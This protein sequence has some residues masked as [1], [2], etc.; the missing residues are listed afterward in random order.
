MKTKVE[1]VID[2][3]IRSRIRAFYGKSG[4][5]TR[6]EIRRFVLDE[7]EQSVR[8]L[9]DAKPKRLAPKC[10]IC[11]R[12]KRQAGK[13]DELGRCGDC[14]KAAAAAPDASVICC[15]CGKPHGEHGGRLGN[16]CPLSRKVKP[17]S[18]FSA[19]STVNLKLEGRWIGAAYPETPV[20]D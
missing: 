8:E 14:L 11:Q 5:A 16:A 6:K 4:K 7:L 12:P 18:T 20:R 2:D 9:P 3:S 13:L 15:R 10:S 17:G 1:W 19:E